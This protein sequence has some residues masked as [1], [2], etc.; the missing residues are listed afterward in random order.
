MRRY[1]IF[2]GSKTE[3]KRL[4]KLLRYEVQAYPKAD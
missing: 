4:R 1:I 3:K 2:R